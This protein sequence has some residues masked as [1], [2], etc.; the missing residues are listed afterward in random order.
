MAWRLHRALQWPS[1]RTTAIV[2]PD[3]SGK[4]S[5]IDDLRSGPQGKAF[6]FKR[7]KRMFRKPLFY[8][9]QEP[10]NVRDEK[11]LWLV[12]PVA[13]TVFSLSRLCTGWRKPLILDRYFYDY[14]VRN[15]RRNSSGQFHRIA[16][17]GL[18]SR[19]APPPQRLIIASCPPE[20]IYRRKQEMTKP[21]IASMYDMYLD[22]VQRGRLP[23]TLF[24][25]T[26]ASPELSGLHVL[27]FLGDPES[28]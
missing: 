27:F 17:Y 7:F 24:C 28:A 18:C 12:L 3:G 22:Q 26:G 9:G 20:I 10:R 14:F 15:V 5:L 21:A 8:W 1:W 6:Y 2:G 16:A 4:T 19:L 23:S 25:Y 11:R 13:W